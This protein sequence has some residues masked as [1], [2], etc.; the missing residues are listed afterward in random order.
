M[1]KSHIAFI[2]ADA[3]ARC[4]SRRWCYRL[5]RVASDWFFRCASDGRRAVMSN[6]GRIR[7]FAGCPAGEEE[8]FALAR[9]TFRNF[10]KY[11]ADFFWFTG[12]R[13]G[14]LAG[15][16]HVSDRSRLQ[17]DRALAGG[18]G[19]LGVTAHLGNWEAGPAVLAGMGM[20]VNAVVM[21]MEDRRTDR[22][23]Q[24]RRRSRGIN[25]ISIGSAA[26]DSVAALRRGEIVALVGDR[27]YTRHSA[28]FEFMGAPASFP[29]GPAKICSLS[30]AP[31][32]AGFLVR[33]A[34]DSFEMLLHD[35]IVPRRGMPWQ[36]IQAELLRILED[37]I[38]SYPTQWFIFDDFWACP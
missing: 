28:R 7:R 31:I 23:F 26:R 20:K 19:V 9:E 14:L 34:N 3:A 6:I 18:R 8:L 4:L 5:S 38:R 37:G 21:P 32:L 22:L 29:V 27:D 1:R 24:A 33:V 2:V 30:G 12:P 15:L 16:V 17:L 25:V 35:P 36:E 11:L 10:G 13:A